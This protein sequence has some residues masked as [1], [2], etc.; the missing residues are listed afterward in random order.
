[1]PGQTPNTTTSKLIKNKEPGEDGDRPYWKDAEDENEVEA[2]ARSLKTAREL[3][4]W[5]RHRELS[6]RWKTSGGDT[7]L[8]YLGWT[9]IM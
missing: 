9:L 5:Q 7:I 8:S 3:R 6:A 4:N 1:M 2:K